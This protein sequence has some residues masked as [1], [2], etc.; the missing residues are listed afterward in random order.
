MYMGGERGDNTKI[1]CHGILILIL[2]SRCF[3]LTHLTHHNTKVCYADG[4]KMM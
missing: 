4:A 3:Y 1:G 2:I